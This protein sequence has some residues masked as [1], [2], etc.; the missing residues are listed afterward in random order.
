MTM[1]LDYVSTRSVSI[2]SCRRK[3]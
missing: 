3:W 2:W 1:T